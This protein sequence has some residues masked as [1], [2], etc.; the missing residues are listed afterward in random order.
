MAKRHPLVCLA[1]SEN[2][3]TTYL[4]LLLAFQDAAAG[5]P[6]AAVDIVF[7]SHPKIGT[8]NLFFSF[9]LNVELYECIWK[10]NAFFSCNRT[11]DNA[12]KNVYN[13]IKSLLSR[14]IA[15]FHRY[16]R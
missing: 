8:I 3:A 10:I 5:V 9:S 16:M 4:P 12:K 13:E 11:A 7:S 1:T 6:N 14:T 15:A 2:E